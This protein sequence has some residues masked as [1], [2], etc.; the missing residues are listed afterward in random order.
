MNESDAKSLSDMLAI[1]DTTDALWNK[2]DMEELLAHQLKSPLDID[3][4][5]HDPAAATSLHSVRTTMAEPPQTFGELFLHEHPPVEVLRWV[6]EFGKNQRRSSDTVLPREL[7]TYLYFTS[8][9]AAL[10]R[11]GQRISELSDE[12]LEKGFHWLLAQPWVDEDSRTLLEQAVE[13]LE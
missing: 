6:K 10:I 13:E 7:A 11:G 5:E 4:A 3:L 1:D 9:A 2:E 12:K 8:I